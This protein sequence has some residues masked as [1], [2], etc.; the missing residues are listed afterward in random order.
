MKNKKE[1]KP[2]YSFS[3][4]LIIFMGVIVAA[5]VALIIVICNL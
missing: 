2:E 4:G 3:W 1:P 5:M